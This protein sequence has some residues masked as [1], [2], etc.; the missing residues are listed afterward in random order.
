MSA[1]VLA[2]WV[3]SGEVGQ[4]YWVV[5]FLSGCKFFFLQISHQCLHQARVCD[6][7]FSMVSS[8]KQF[9]ILMQSYLFVL[10]LLLVS[11]LSC[12]M[13]PTNAKVKN[14][15]RSF[16]WRLCNVFVS[17]LALPIYGWLHISLCVAS[18]KGCGSSS[19]PT[20][21]VAAPWTETTFSILASVTVPVSQISYI[22]QSR[23]QA[24]STFFFFPSIDTKPQFSSQRG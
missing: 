23:D 22:L 9:F 16:L 6:Y 13:N 12:L 24:P 11:F 1:L 14:H 10:I 8:D 15:F 17:S 21:T 3:C 5:F 20:A 18:I 4:L 7:I 2:M 19:L